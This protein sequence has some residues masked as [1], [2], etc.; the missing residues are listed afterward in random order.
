MLPPRTFGNTARP[1]T[2]VHLALQVSRE[3]LLRRWTGTCL[4]LKVATP[5]HKTTWGGCSSRARTACQLTQQVPCNGCRQQQSKAV[6]QLGSIWAHA[7]NG[8]WESALSMLSQHRSATCMQ[9]SWGTMLLLRGFGS[10]SKTAAHKG[11]LPP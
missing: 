10:C 9:L 8:E 4:L 2:S 6:Q 1:V 5:L 3:T 11:Q 7:S